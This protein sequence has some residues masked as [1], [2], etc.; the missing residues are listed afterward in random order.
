MNKKIEFNDK[1]LYFLKIFIGILGTCL[2]VFGAWFAVDFIKESI[3]ARTMLKDFKE[4]DEIRKA[5]EKSLSA[6]AESIKTEGN[7]SWINYENGKIFVISATAIIAVLLVG[8]FGVKINEKIWSSDTENIQKILE[9]HS[10]T[11]GN[12]HETLRRLIAGIQNDR[13][14]INQCIEKIDITNNDNI[15]RI[16]RVLTDLQAEIIE[17]I[18]KVLNNE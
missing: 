4:K 9:N 3:E 11:I 14:S 10:N 7:F 2:L 5:F 6:G 16:G 1:Q 12:M 18:K 8:S 17:N 15:D 13:G